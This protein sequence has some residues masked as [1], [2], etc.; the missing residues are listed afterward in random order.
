MRKHHIGEVV[1]F[2]VPEDACEPEQLTGTV[3]QA[4]HQNITHPLSIYWIKV[5]GVEGEYMVF[6]D[7]IIEDHL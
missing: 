2:R 6:D 1:T 5:E 3:E 4:I 7:D